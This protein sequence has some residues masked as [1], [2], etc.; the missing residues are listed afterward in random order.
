LDAEGN[1]S[2]PFDQDRSL[3]NS[4]MIAEGQ[5]LLDASATGSDLTEYHVEAAIAC[6]Q[7]T[8]HRAEDTDWGH[9]VSLY[10]TLIAIHPS[11][12]GRIESRDRATSRP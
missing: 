12:C 9:I 5:R 2:S 11:P 4:Q 7:A 8:A 3:W 10:N 6:V 1:L